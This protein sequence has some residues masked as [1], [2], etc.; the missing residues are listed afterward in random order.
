MLE[1]GEVL[2]EGRSLNFFIL[3]SAFFLEIGIPCWS[4][5]SLCGFAGRHLNC[6][7]NGM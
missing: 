1:A 5:T 3:P 6:S 7:A 2:R 4:Y